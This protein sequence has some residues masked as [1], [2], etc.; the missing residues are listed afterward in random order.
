MS[1]CII[2]DE[3]QASQPQTAHAPLHGY[4]TQNDKLFQNHKFQCVIF[5][6]LLQ[7]KFSEELVIALIYET[8]AIQVS[9]TKLN[10][11][12]AIKILQTPTSIITPAAI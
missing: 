12:Y 5:T 6:W 4:C 1:L 3:I 7:C 8:L 10:F 2:R 11:I 9:R